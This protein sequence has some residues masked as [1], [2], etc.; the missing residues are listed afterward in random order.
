MSLGKTAANSADSRPLSLL[1]I[2]DSPDDQ[3]ILRRA[4]DKWL[5]VDFKL[6]DVSSARGALS[7]LAQKGFDL[8]L[9]DFELPD[10][11]G[12]QVMKEIQKRGIKTPILFITGQRNPLVA[13]GVLHNGAKYYLNKDKIPRD[14]QL[15]AQ[16]INDFLN[17]S[18]RRNF[19]R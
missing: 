6:E 12:L 18:Q 4:L 10:M 1:H 3:V 8:I 13:A 5:K 7:I 16:V 19:T 17:E 14:P 11:N 15:V 2:E 9:L